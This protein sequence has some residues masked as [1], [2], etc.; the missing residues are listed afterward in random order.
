MTFTASSTASGSHPIGPSRPRGRLARTI[1]FTA[2]VVS[3]ATTGLG[4]VWVLAPGLNP[5]ADGTMTSLL[6]AV[7]APAAVAIAALALGVAGVALAVLLLLD[8]RMP[9]RALVGLGAA[10]LALA[11]GLILGSMGTI[12]YAGYLFGLA[13]VVAGVAT[14]VVT[15]VR[16]PRLGLLLLAVLLAVLAAAVWLAGLTIDGVTEFAI[17]FGDALAAHAPNIAVSAVIVVDALV[18]AAI[19]I[20]AL[21]AASAGQR[22]ESW[23]VRHRRILTI[24]AALGPVPYAVA[25][26]SWLTPW[27]LF[28][29]MPED[30]PPSLL[31][32]GLMLGGGAVAASVLTLGLILP[33]G[34]RFP[35]WMPRIGGRSVPAAA[36]VVPGSIAA[37]VICISA[38]PMF[39]TTVGG[40]DA[41][42]DA[43]LVNLV[44]PLWFWGPM[45]ALA[46]WAYA[47]WRR[48]EV[49]RG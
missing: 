4:L 8:A 34:R 6:S 24:L 25:R 43:L 1:A 40:A 16:T 9:H 49:Q 37:G 22:F 41:P 45:L 13:A 15:L 30:L 31:A 7:A 32:T 33:W 23:L 27:P 26:V 42:V 18:W 44:L 39:V 36:A 21:R 17:A 20:S 38:A 46:V 3:A 10:A 19:A 29:P 47:A 35:R 48:D 28:G 5:F 2:V 12:A 14:M 11:V